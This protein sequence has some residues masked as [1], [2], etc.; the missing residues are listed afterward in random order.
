[1]LM[2]IK[3]GNFNVKMRSGRRGNEG[4]KT[5]GHENMTA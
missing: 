2:L 3:E 1:M 5:R 4:M